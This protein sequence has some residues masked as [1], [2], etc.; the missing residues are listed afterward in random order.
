MKRLRGKLTYA[1]VMVTIL[2]FVVLG[3]GAAF[4]A[5]Q[6]KKNSVGTKQLK[7]NSVATAKIKNSAVTAA[8][9][10]MVPWEQHKSKTTQ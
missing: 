4:A 1:N 7:K 5:T 9:S 6:L 8:R 10:P 2:A 3:G